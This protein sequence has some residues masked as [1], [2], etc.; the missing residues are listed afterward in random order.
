MKVQSKVFFIVLLALI[1]SCN[2][3]DKVNE[4]DI[5]YRLENL[6]HQG[7]KSKSIS[8]H[9]GD[10]KYSA[11]EVPIQYYILKEVGSQKLAAVDS[12]YEENKR[13]RIMEF[14]FTQDGEQDL[15]KEEF[16]HMDYQ[17]AVKYISFKIQDD[18]Y[19]VTGHSD[20][21]KCSGITFERSFK[22][23]PYN[24]VLLFFTDVNPAENIQLV[25]HD[26]LFGRGTIKF[27][28]KE[29]TIKL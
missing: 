2:K 16:T 20:T 7:W 9:L 6:E 4:Q 26:R 10:I 13:E 8:Q 27:R 14:T 29:P 22:V 12:I 28:F 23:G 21:I 15:L 5:Y 17:S 19:A 1:F 25:Y 18:F 24:K 11:T 3:K